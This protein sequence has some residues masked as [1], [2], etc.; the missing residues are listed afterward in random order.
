M[1]V[2]K[3]VCF[4]FNDVKKKNYKKH[5]KNKIIFCKYNNNNN[6]NKYCN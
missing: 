6:N 2:Y 5:N 3:F 1:N 4:T